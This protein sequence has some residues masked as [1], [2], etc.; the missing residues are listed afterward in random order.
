MFRPLGDIRAYIRSFYATAFKPIYF[1]LMVLMLSIIIYFNYFPRFTI[2]HAGLS[3]LQNFGYNYLL[4]FIPFTA[5]FILQIFFF[6]DTGYLQKGSL[7]LIIFLAPAFFS[8]RVNFT[9]LQPIVKQHWEGP[10]QKYWLAVFNLITRA[11]V[12]FPVLLFWWFRDRLAEPLY[13]LKKTTRIQTYFL[14]L[15]MM[16][17]LLILAANNPGFLKQYPRSLHAT[18]PTLAMQ[19]AHWLLYEFFY[20]LDFFSIEFFFRGFLIIAFIRICG[21]R[22]IIPAACFYCC[23]HLGKPMPEAISSFFGGLLLGI[24]SYHTKSIWGG[25]L[26][27]VGIA[28]I[29]ELLA[30]QHYHLL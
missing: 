5:A 24:I 8:F 1:L 28:A 7:W 29:M 21:M 10:E 3:W 15:L 23:I 17:P 4:Y 22:A 20:A 12:I 27:H 11:V 26:I 9:F 2:D 14:L 25:L 18:D 19:Q 6:K 13:G 30:F 16:L